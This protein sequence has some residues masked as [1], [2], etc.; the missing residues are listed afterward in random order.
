MASSEEIEAERVRFNNWVKE[1]QVYENIPE[2]LF[3]YSEVEPELVWTEF[4]DENYSFVATGYTAASE[5]PRIPVISYYL[6]KK[7][8]LEGPD[9]DYI[10]VSISLL[11]DCGDCGAVG[12]DDEGEE[13]SNCEGLG[14]TWVEFDLPEDS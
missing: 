5:S 8:W 1:Y 4:S 13:C 6:S 3:D 9:D 12:E 14:G 2:D 7:P 11:L 10:D